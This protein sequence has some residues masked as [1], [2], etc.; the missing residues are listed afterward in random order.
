MDYFIEELKN[1]KIINTDDIKTMQEYINK[2]YFK[3][4]SSEKAKMLSNTIHHILDTNLKELPENYRQT[5]KINTL[6]NTFSKNKA[7][8]FMYDIFLCCIKSNL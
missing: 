7:S 2:K 5:V 6:K 1:K 4:P 3:I 8:I